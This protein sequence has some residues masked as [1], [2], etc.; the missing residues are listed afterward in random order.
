MSAADV[1]FVSADLS[2]PTTV[3][4]GSILRVPVVSADPA[5][6]DDG[7]IVYDQ[8]LDK[9]RTRVNGAWTD[10]GGGG[11]GGGGV[12]AES[13]FYDAVDVGDALAGG[14]TEIGGPFSFGALYQALH[15]IKFTGVKFHATASGAAPSTWTVKA[16][17]NGSVVASGTLLVSAVGS[18]SVLFG[19]TNGVGALTPYTAALGDFVTISAECQSSI[20]VSAE[21]SG[22]SGIMGPSVRMIYSALYGV[23][24]GVRPSTGGNGVYG[25]A[26]IL[27]A[28]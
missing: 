25:I 21:A 7:E 14:W 10:M 6:G 13:L 19:T 27:A 2:S 23:G 22:I 9:F 16:W 12:T 17:V 26:P 11:G 28:P 4:V 5:G 15:A 18:Y 3:R 20:S 1:P 24:A 8:V